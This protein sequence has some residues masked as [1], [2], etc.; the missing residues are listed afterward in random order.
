MDTQKL[1]GSLVRHG[2]SALSGALLSIGIQ[3]AAVDSLA[4]ALVPILGGVVTY[5]VSQGWS[6]LEKR[7]R[8]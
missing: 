8:R 6:I 2:I 3:Q 4:N 7:I 1:V 5:G